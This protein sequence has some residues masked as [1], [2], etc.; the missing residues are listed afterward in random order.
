MIDNEHCFRAIKEWHYDAPVSAALTLSDW[1]LSL[2]RSSRRNCSAHHGLHFTIFWISSSVTS[3]PSRRN[4]FLH[5][6]RIVTCS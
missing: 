6:T 2:W 3:K 1:A 4:T 5:V